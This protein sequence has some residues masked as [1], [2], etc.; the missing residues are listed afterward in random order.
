MTLVPA[1]GTAFCKYKPTAAEE[2]RS[3]LLTAAQLRASGWKITARSTKGGGAL[4]RAGRGL[5]YQSWRMRNRIHVRGNEAPRDDFP[6]SRPGLQA[7]V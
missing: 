7:Q 5:V 6:G 1:V 4:L 2:P 3:A